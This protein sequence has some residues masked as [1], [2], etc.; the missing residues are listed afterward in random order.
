MKKWKWK[1]LE[2]GG[3]GFLRRRSMVVLFGWIAE[4]GTCTKDVLLRKAYLDL[5]LDLG[6]I[7]KHSIGC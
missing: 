5:H 2:D 1:I 7:C 4:M 3:R 6:C